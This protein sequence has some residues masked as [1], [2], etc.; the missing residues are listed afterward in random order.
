MLKNFYTMGGGHFWED[1]F[2][3]QKWRIQR[4]FTSKKCRLLDNWDIRRHEGSFE[5][6]RKAFLDYIEAFELARQKG[7]MVIMLHGLAESKNIFKPL[8]RAVLEKGLMAA[9]INYPSTQKTLNGHARQLDFFLNHLEDVETVSFVTKG[10][11]SLL[12]RKIFSAPSPWQ[13]RLKIGRIVEIEPMNHGSPLLKKL[14][15]NKVADF[16]LGPMAQELSTR[17]AEALPQLPSDIATGIILCPSLTTKVIES[18]AK[19]S[20]PEITP[21][22]E[23]EFCGAKEVIKMNVWQINPFANKDLVE[24]TVKFLSTG[25]F[26]ATAKKI[27]KL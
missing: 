24:Q 13:Q 2:F 14:S 18:L 1:V 21:E 27:K 6:C 16:V 23:R 25:H 19:A 15:K 20:R 10:I 9:A 26:G 8:W 11:G 7:H 12:L 4:N 22:S 3:Y 17:K 5:D